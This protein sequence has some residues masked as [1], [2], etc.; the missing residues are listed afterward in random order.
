MAHRGCT[1]QVLGN[2]DQ[3]LEDFNHAIQLFPDNTYYIT[4]RG[5]T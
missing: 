5:S 1:Y 4:Y 3:A 2:Y